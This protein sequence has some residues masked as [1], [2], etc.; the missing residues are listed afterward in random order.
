MASAA[1]PATAPVTAAEKVL[2]VL[3]ETTSPLPLDG[4]RKACRMRTSVLCATLAGLTH[5]H[6]VI[7]TGGG[8]LPATAQTPGA[9]P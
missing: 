7:K 2:R 9:G 3:A 6:R 5:D 8:Y 1:S 4:L